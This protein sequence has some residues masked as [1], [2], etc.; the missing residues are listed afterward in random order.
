MPLGRVH[1]HAKLVPVSMEDVS[2]AT[3]HES[4]GSLK[5]VS[6]ISGGF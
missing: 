2:I 6:E 3:L 1:V 4:H 5:F